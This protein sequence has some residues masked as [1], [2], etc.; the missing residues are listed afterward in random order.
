M[1]VNQTI[2]FE[3]ME[4]IL[5]CVS[6]PAGRKRTA[7]FN[8]KGEYLKKYGFEVGD[9]V[10]VEISQHKIVITKNQGTELL[11]QMKLKNPNINCLIEEFGLI[12]M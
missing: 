12:E 4:R 2:L 11:S 5:K 3:I 6:F 10:K 1:F 8:L 9:F 7:G